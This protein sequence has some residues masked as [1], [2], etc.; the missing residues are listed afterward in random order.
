[1]MNAGTNPK[2]FLA[3][4]LPFSSVCLHKLP[5]DASFEA[6]AILKILSGL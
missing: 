2:G 1:M 5:K 6:S 3:A 4:T